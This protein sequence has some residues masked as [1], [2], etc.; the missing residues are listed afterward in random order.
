MREIRRRRFLLNYCAIEILFLDGRAL[1]IAFESEQAN[2]EATKLVLRIVFI[3]ITFCTAFQLP[4]AKSIANGAALFFHSTMGVWQAK[5]F[6]LPN[7]P[8]RFCWAHAQ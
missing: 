3:F 2:S 7:A 6:C 1:F 5:Q 4:Y 8:Q